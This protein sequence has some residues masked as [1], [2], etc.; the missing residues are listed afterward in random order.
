MYFRGRSERVGKE[1]LLPRQRLHVAIT[2]VRAGRRRRA[3]LR[4]LA[5]VVLSIVA[6]GAGMIRDL[7][8]YAKK[9]P[10]TR[11]KRPITPQKRPTDICCLLLRLVQVCQ[12]NC[13]S[14]LP[15]NRSLLPYGRPLLTQAIRP[16]WTL[17]GLFCHMVGLFCHMLGLFCHMVG[18]FCRV[19]GLFCHMVGHT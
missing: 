19:I 14:L 11:Q 9:R 13:R 6:A 2:R 8:I 7:Q 16:L 1:G 5:P 12:Y 17:V 3:H 10:I 4:F 18:L 15:C